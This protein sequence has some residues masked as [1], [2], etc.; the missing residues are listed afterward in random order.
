MWENCE[1]D[2]VR[3]KAIHKAIGQLSEKIKIF[4]VPFPKKKNYSA[5]AKCNQPIDR[6]LISPSNSRQ[7]SHN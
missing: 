3:S 5:K 2:L 6:Q 1:Y 7:R 4:E